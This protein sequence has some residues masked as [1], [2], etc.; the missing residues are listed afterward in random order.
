[1]PRPQYLV[2]SSRSPRSPALQ[3]RVGAENQGRAA[4]KG[5]LVGGGAGRG[6]KAD[7]RAVAPGVPRRRAKR[8]TC[9]TYKDKECVYYC[10]LDI[11]W[12]NTPERTVPYGLSNYR[13]SFRGKRST[14]QLCRSSESLDW[15]LS[16]C[17][18]LD[19]QD[20]Q[21]T[22]FCTRTQDSRC[23]QEKRQQRKSKAE[24]MNTPSFSSRE[25]QGSF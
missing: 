24:K 1:A 8:C 6:G 15:S 5:L 2:D 7:G 4:A 17:S 9:Y 21:C 18:C 22:L 11:I 20:K 23:N 12:I 25:G 13:G 3:E 19:A 10:H 16:R 14:A